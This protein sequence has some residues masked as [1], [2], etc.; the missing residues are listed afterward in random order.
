[1][2]VGHVNN[3]QS[4][5]SETSFI[6]QGL[7]CRLTE[8]GRRPR[9]QNVRS[10]GGEWETNRSEITREKKLGSGNYGVVYKGDSFLQD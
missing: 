3:E 6:F 10:E 2:Q 1:M 4:I 5:D 9:Q 7:A 8:P